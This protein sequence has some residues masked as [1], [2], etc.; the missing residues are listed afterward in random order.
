MYAFV[1][2]IV[3]FHVSNGG[4]VCENCTYFDDCFWVEFRLE[5]VVKLSTSH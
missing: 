1:V 3:P 2:G 5:L 4:F